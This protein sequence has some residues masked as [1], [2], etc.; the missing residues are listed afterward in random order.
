MSKTSE[1]NDCTIK[2]IKEGCEKAGIPSEEKTI[3]FAVGFLAGKLGMGDSDER[4]EAPSTGTFFLLNTHIVITLHTHTHTH[5]EGKVI[6]CKAAVMM[7]QGAD[8]EIKEI[9]V[10]PVRKKT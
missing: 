8:L 4:N 9:Q 5:T 6:T 3:A 1:D 7:T 10:A 2:Q